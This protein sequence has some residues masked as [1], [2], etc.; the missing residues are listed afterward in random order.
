MLTRGKVETGGRG[1]EDDVAEAAAVLGIKMSNIQ[2]TNRNSSS[3]E[4]EAAVNMRKKKSKN[5]ID[6]LT[7]DVELE[8]FDSVSEGDDIVGGDNSLLICTIC[9]KVSKNI[10]NFNSHR[11]KKHGIRQRGVRKDKGTKKFPLMDYKHDIKEEPNATVNESIEEK[12][13]S[14]DDE[15]KRVTC[16]ECGKAFRDQGTLRRHELIHLPEDQKPHKCDF[17]SKRFCQAVQKRSHM[18]MHQMEG[19]REDNVE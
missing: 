19:E 12:E 16:G 6:F 13:E 4:A 17:C 2:M 5:S 10:S 9:D 1:V 7:P 3:I 14:E 8:E 11:L 15:S 18:N